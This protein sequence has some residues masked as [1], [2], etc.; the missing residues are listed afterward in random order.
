[1]MY[2]KLLTNLQTTISFQTEISETSYA[3]VFTFNLVNIIIPEDP[4]LRGDT[5]QQVQD[6]INNEVNYKNEEYVKA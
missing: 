1:M 3:V 2:Y 5:Y 4:D 6:A